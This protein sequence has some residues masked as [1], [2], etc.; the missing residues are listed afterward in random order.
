MLG[1]DP[2][3][4][5]INDGS[6]NKNVAD[7]L[8]SLKSDFTID[9]LKENMGKGAALR[10]GVQLS[11]APYTLFTDIDF[12]YTVESIIAVWNELEGGVHQ[13]VLGRRDNEYYLKVPYFRKYLS[14]SFRTCMKFFLRLKTDDTQCGL[15]A[16]DKNG[17]ELFLKTSINRF[18]FDLEFVHY[19]SVEN[20]INLIGIPVK[21]RPGIEFSKMPLKI[22][23]TEG[24]N[25]CKIIFKALFYKLR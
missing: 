18:L 11:N 20:S 16:F 21:L 22:L 19:C 12:P 5:I 13:V 17:K 24:G 9:H 23:L 4:I 25:F 6:T 7:E 15:K 10:K 14:K 8:N 1:F 2:N 3:I